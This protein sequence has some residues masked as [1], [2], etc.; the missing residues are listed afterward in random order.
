MPGKV[1]QPWFRERK[2]AW[3]VCINGRQHALGKDRDEAFRR[4]HLLMAGETPTP[5]PEPPKATATTRQEQD[6][7]G[8]QEAITAMGTPIPALTVNALAEAYL[9]ACE[10]RLAANPLRVARMFVRSPDSTAHARLTASAKPMCGGGWRSTR[11]GGK[12]RR[13]PP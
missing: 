4:Y 1:P 10:R 12:A 8:R 9:M 5:S 2:Q 3:Y 11:H 13:T 7:R 6:S